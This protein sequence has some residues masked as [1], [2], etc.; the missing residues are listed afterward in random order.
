MA[1]SMRIFSRLAVRVQRRDGRESLQVV[2]PVLETTERS[3]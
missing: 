1:L 2:P 3:T